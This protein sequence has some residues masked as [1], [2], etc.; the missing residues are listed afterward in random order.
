MSARATKNVV[1]DAAFVQ[2][3]ASAAEP[4][5]RRRARGRLLQRHRAELNGQS[6]HIPGAI[7]IPFSQMTDDQQLIDRDRVAALFRDAG[8]KPGDTIVAYCHIG[9]QATAVIFGAR[10]LGYPAMLYDGSFQDWAVNHRGP[11]EK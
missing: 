9:Q 5:A 8:I 11:V 6:G 3:V 7:N 2:S 10:L 1:V 4:Q